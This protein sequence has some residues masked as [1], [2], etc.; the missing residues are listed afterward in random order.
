MLDWKHVV[1]D[2]DNNRL[3]FKSGPSEM[4]GCT[5]LTVRSTQRL[6]RGAHLV[7]EKVRLLPGGKV[8]A[9]VEPVEMDQ[10]GIRFLCPTLRGDID[11]FRESTCSAACFRRATSSIDAE[12]ATSSRVTSTS[13]SLVAS[14]GSF[15]IRLVRRNSAA[16]K[17]CR[18]QWRKDYLHSHQAAIDR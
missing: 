15:G 14:A 4:G 16:Q 17:S 8:P 9:F 2:W 11:V 10:L 6:E 1:E 5:R 18:A 3:I 12:S 13:N 7:N